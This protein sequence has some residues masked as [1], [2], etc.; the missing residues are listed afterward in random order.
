MTDILKIS[1]NYKHSNINCVWHEIA[2]DNNLKWQIFYCSYYY[3]LPVLLSYNVCRSYMQLFYFSKYY[4]TPI[5]LKYHPIYNAT[6][7][8]HEIKIPRQHRIDKLL[9]Y[10]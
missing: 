8:L 1:V 6:L 9:L 7:L 5:Y 3:V 10:M 4:H 2:K